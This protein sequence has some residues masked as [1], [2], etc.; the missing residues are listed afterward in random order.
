VCKWVRIA[1]ASAS[2]AMG[3]LFA[4]LGLARYT[5][6]HNPTFDLAMY[7]R[8]AWGF[9]H[10]DL[11]DPVVGSIAL[12]LH[13][14]PVLA[15]LGL[16]GIAF[17]TAEVLLVAQAAAFAA[18]AWP[19]AR[20]G[21]RRFGSAGAIAV[22]AAW[23]LHPNLG[24]VAGQEFHPGSMAILPLAWGMDALD[25]NDARG[26]LWAT[27]G[28]LLC[29]EDLGLMTAL[30]AA[31]LLWARRGHAN[32]S[33]RPAWI[34]LGVSLGVVVVFAAVLHPL[35]APAEGSLEAHFGEWGESLP[36]VLWTWLTEPARVA[37]HLVQP[38]GAAYLAAVL[39]TLLFL[40]LLSPRWLLVALPVLGINLMSHFPAAVR[41][42]EHYLTP[43]LPALMAA[44]VEGAGR[45]ASWIRRLPR[46][47]V[48]TALATGMAVAHLQ[49]GGTPASADFDASL[50]QRDERTE[51]AERV[52]AAIPPAVSVQAPPPLL[53]H[54]A[55]R[56]RIHRAPPPERETRFVVLDLSHRERYQGE[57]TLLRTA[58]EPNARIWLGRP[59]HAVIVHAPPFVLLERGKAPFDG[60]GRE[61]LVGRSSPEAGV[62]ITT[63]LSVLGAEHLGD[64]RVAF[65]VVARTPCWRDMALRVGVLPRPTRTELP[66][67]GIL[68]PAHLRRGDRLRTVHRVPGASGASVVHVGAVRSS[69]CKPMHGDPYSVA[70]GL[71]TR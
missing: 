62:P 10:G 52:V 66:F 38:D 40:P 46:W 54:L 6:F 69:G 15:P 11:W 45:S 42:E 60:V 12:G 18:A 17:G 29:R 71:E 68:S 56:H 20:M 1:V 51:A 43:A 58:Q 7:V 8:M 47:V 50:F 4:W 23:L 16:L 22:A 55:E 25:R 3:A 35:F 28:A 41:F 27:A 39:G 57:E 53:P 2:A 24:H 31:S 63:C 33:A 49:I 44:A 48:P 37:A 5:S 21:E 26:L 34:A 61:Y 70:I 64:D 32:G 59:D 67:D 65:D 19:L 36:Q 13:L 30:M 9:V 14:S